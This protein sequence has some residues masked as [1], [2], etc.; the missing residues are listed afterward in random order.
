MFRFRQ[1]KD[2]YVSLFFYYQ[3]YTCYNINS[4]LLFN[5]IMQFT[6]IDVNTSCSLILC[7]SLHS[8]HIYLSYQSCNTSHVHSAISNHIIIPSIFS[9]IHVIHNIFM[10]LSPFIHIIF[11][12]LFNH[13]FHFSNMQGI[14][15]TLILCRSHTH[16]TFIYLS[17]HI[18]HI[19]FI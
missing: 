11:L 2:F 17:N 9:F 14:S 19:T 18:I 1:A 5:A 7:H 3:F 12:C 13:R 16:I 10:S 15:C 4:F 6:F 8:Y